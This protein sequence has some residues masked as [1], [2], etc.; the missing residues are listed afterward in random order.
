MDEVSDEQILER[1]KEEIHNAEFKIKF[2]ITI[3]KETGI[4]KNTNILG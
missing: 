1:V 3:N 2:T 4:Y